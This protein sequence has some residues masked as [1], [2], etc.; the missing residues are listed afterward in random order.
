METIHPE[1]L[2]EER[3]A[4][5]IAGRKLES[6]YPKSE[7]FKKGE[8]LLRAENLSVPGL[9]DNVSFSLHAGEI[10]GITGLM[11]AG[12]TEVAKN[13]FWC[14]WKRQSKINR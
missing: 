6:K 3:L 7:R 13:N 4:E 12:K 10:L 2:D 14:L 8:G 9:L 5:L 11:G 1:E